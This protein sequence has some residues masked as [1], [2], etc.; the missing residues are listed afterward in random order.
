MRLR[1]PD[2]RNP[3]AL[4]GRGVFVA[5]QPGYSK[6]WKAPSPDP[7]AAYSNSVCRGSPYD[8]PEKLGFNTQALG[9][10]SAGGISPSARRVAT[11][12]DPLPSRSILREKVRLMRKKP[13]KVW[14]L[15]RPT[16]VWRRPGSIRLSE[17]TIWPCQRLTV[18]WFPPE[19]THS[20]SWVIVAEVNSTSLPSTVRST[21]S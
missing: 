14:S 7:G 3:L 16:K 5:S 13:P 19:P 21:R 8:R 1:C 20:S 6:P 4:T 17:V 18:F 15:V 10:R 9:N 2:T 12:R 11:R